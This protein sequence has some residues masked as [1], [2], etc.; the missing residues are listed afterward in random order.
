MELV[1]LE[2]TGYHQCNPCVD[3]TKFA[4]TGGA[5][6]GQEGQHLKL[7]LAR[8]G[9]PPLDAIGFGLGSWLDH[10]PE[11]I[12]VAYQLEINEWNGIS[13]LATQLAGHSSGG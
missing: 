7:K 3:V 11:R 4:G 13:Q 6:S 5:R 1:R 8:A 12:D 10:M 2:P 9:Q